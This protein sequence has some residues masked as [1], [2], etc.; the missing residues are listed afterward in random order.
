MR[1]F[2]TVSVH[3][4]VDASNLQVEADILYD[5]VRN[6]EETTKE[7]CGCNAIVHFQVQASP[8]LIW[9]ALIS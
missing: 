4:D 1:F 6:Y 2:G 3:R 7:F 8:R 9:L 5:T